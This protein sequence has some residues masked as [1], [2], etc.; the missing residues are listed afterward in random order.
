MEYFIPKDSS[1]LFKSNGLQ[2]KDID[3]FSLRLN[4]YVRADLFSLKNEYEGV[5]FDTNIET[6]RVDRYYNT[7]ELIPYEQNSLFVKNDWKLTLG[8]GSGSVYNTSMTLHHIYGVPY[9]PAQSIKGAFRSYIVQ[10]YFADELFSEKYKDKYSKF[11]E[12]VLF[13]K[14]KENKKYV[15]KWFVDIFGSNDQQGKVIFFDAFSKDFKIVK[16]IMT[17]HYKD[18]YGDNKNRVAPTDTQDP[19][20]INFLTLEDASFKICFASKENIEIEDGIFQGKKI[21]ELIEKELST[22]LEF[23][24]IG[25]K[26]SV[27]YGY[28]TA[29]SEPRSLIEREW[30]IAKETINPIVLKSFIEKFPNSKLSDLANDKL[31]V[32]LNSIERQKREEEDNKLKKAEGFSLLENCTDLN[33]GLKI[34]N[35]SLGKNPKFLSEQLELLKLFYAKNKNKKKYAKGIYKKYEKWM[36]K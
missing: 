23:F 24:G 26:T 36:S 2:S 13:K 20:P 3:N 19:M 11:E 5:S 6:D 10:T 16:D 1:E 27:G 32:L 7:L 17:P 21:L 33:D 12:E 29:E 15:H 22:S 35:N 8:M 34:I 30:D 14:D 31:M 4:R 9:L 18:Y 28:F 25:G